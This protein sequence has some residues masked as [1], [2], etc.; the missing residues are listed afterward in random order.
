MEAPSSTAHAQ[1][2]GLLESASQTTVQFP[3][4]SEFHEELQLSQEGTRD[5]NYD[6]DDDDSNEDASAGHRSIYFVRGNNPPPKSHPKLSGPQH[7]LFFHGGLQLRRGRADDITVNHF[8]LAYDIAL[9]E[10]LE[11]Y[12]QIQWQHG[13]ALVESQVKSVSSEGA[14]LRYVKKMQYK[15]HQVPGFPSPGTEP[16]EV[17]LPWAELQPLL[18]AIRRE[19]RSL[20][21]VHL[22]RSAMPEQQRSLCGRG[23]TNAKRQR[24]EDRHN[25]TE[26]CVTFVE[27]SFTQQYVAERLCEAAAIATQLVSEGV[28][29]QS[30]EARFA[31][32]R[33][34]NALGAVSLCVQLLCVVTM[35]S[36]TNFIVCFV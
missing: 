30:E 8:N 23:P 14:V 19:D 3:V 12:D 28:S 33:A 10:R 22:Q 17:H 24:E 18:R 5:E 25:E 36:H 9:M 2:R 34:L 35:C 31:L 13:D 20:T 4:L 15:G 21:M 26:M 1:L 32:H 7:N 16:S 6:S 29:V 27:G 11:P